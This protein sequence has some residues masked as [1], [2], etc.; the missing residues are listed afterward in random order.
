[1]P[2]PDG[3]AATGLAAI[4]T[5][6]A[7]ASADQI[8]A[9]VDRAEYARYIRRMDELALLCDLAEAIE[10]SGLFQHPDDAHSLE[11]ILART[12]APPQNHRVAR[13][14]IGSLA[15]N[16]L[17]VKDEASLY[18][19]RL[20]VKQAA[21]TDGWREVDELVMRLN[22][23]SA[24]V[25]D[26]FKATTAN[27]AEVLLASGPPSSRCKFLFPQ[28]RVDVGESLFNATLFNRWG[29]AALAA[30]AATIAG[31]AAKPFRVLEAGAGVGGTSTDVIRALAGSDVEYTFTDLSQFFLNKAKETFGEYPWVRYATYDI[32]ADF[33]AQGFSPNSFDAIIIGDSLHTARHAG[34]T[35]EALRELLAPGGW[36][37]FAEMTRDHYQMMVSI[38]LLLDTTEDFADMR[39]GKDQTFV[40][41][42]DI[43]GL[44]GGDL[45]FAL[46]EADDAFAEIGL[47]VYACQVKT[48]RAPLRPDQ[49][50]KAAAQRLPAVMVPSV[51]QIVDRLPL[52]A[53]GKVDRNRLQSLIPQSSRHAETTADEPADDLERR[54]AALY[55]Q[56]LNLPAVGRS[57]SFYDLG[58]DSL[59]GSQ[60]AGQLI[61]QL[62]ETRRWPFNDLLRVLLQ[63]PSVLE[64]A[65]QLRDAA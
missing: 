34:R 9:D 50:T 39:H 17:L 6:T 38:E 51:V 5:Q 62:P 24:K 10:S 22:P 37:L 58:G 64:L 61:E 26:Y 33:R 23:A 35:L 48:D 59:T 53:N 44:L 16:G 56:V 45:V 2:T 43:L 41:H 18:R 13:R 52:T 25:H 42:P 29:N 47:Y 46:P 36:L 57:P 7:A 14:W 20:L 21:I 30:A 8:T 60:L 65:E 32:N 40:S 49:I 12:Q 54:I 19:A 4:V 3:P 31:P 1:M 27:L 28:G 55:G 15:D 63:G 11:Q